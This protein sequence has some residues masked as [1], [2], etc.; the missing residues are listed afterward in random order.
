M[1][2]ICAILYLCFLSICLFGYENSSPRIN[3]DIMNSKWNA[4]WITCPGVSLT[5]YGVFHFRK[6]FD[7]N[8]EQS[9]FII[10]ISAD[11]RYRLFVNGVEVCKGPARGDLAN[12]HFETVDIADYLEPGENVLAA[13]VWNF[14]EHRPLAQMTNK[15]AFVVQGNSDLEQVVNTGTSWKVFRN[16][17]Y[18]PPSAHTFRTAVGPGEEVDGSKYPYGWVLVDFNDN[19]WKTP[20]VLRNGFP[21][22]RFTGWDWNLIP[23][24]IPFMEYR[25]VRIKEIERAENIEVENGF[26]E[27]NLPLEIPDNRKVKILLDQTYLTTAYP[28]IKVTGGK[29]S[30]VQINY[31]ET[32]VHET[33]VKGN[34]NETCGKTMLS[35]YSDKFHPDGGKSRCF[36]PLWF[37]TFRYLEIIVETKDEP[38]IIEDMY[39]YFTAYPFEERAFFKSN[40][41]TLQSVWEIGWRTARLCAGEIYYDCPYYEQ[42]QYIGD[43]RIQALI[44]LYVAGDSRLM[45]NAIEQFH[46]SQLSSGLTQSRYPSSQPQI[47][48][49]FSLIWIY[50]LH[51]FWMHCDDLAFV[52]KHLNGI[53]N[54]LH[55]YE[56]HISGNGM[57]GPMRWWNFVDWSFSPWNGEK[58]VGGTPPGAIDGNSSVITLQYIDALQKAAE[59]FEAFDDLYLADKYRKE[60]SSLLKITHSLCWSDEK[61]LLSDTPEKISFSQHANVLAILTGM[62]DQNKSIDVF[63]KLL[64]EDHLIQTTFYFKFYLF[65]AMNKVGR[66]DDYLDLLAPWREMINLGLTTFSETPEPTRSDCHAWSAHP[67]YDL[68]ATVCGITPKSPG[69]KSVSIAPNLGG[70][71]FIECRMPH[72]KGDILLNL[73]RKSQSAIE[74]RIFIPHHVE[75]EFNW[76][77]SKV[78]LVGGWQRIDLL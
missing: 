68:L 61:G 73:K 72:P 59:L 46:N 37:R 7:V 44:S 18:I 48:P 69:F 70:L 36:Q 47:I 11:N 3:P 19:D 49:P 25:F 57:L 14:G 24:S 39:T 17:S 26:L 2:K 12:W 31:A 10:H 53:R 16:E 63:D 33:G 5:E 29:G 62:F 71:E 20:R 4:S 75:G 55:W 27:G 13:V 76:K 40:D 74:G 51:D 28:E 65:R 52:K 78:V 43:T 30:S 64:I 54:V 35:L 23:R 22:G 1:I 42:L 50:M 56:Q 60:A 41:S 8:Q 77:G 45:R 6:A 9:E 67:N 58:P 66:A 34:R 15:T 21:D 38:L 32:L